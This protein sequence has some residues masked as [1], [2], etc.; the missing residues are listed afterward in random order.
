GLEPDARA[1]GVR[2]DGPGAAEQRLEVTLGEVVRCRL[3]S[4]H[5]AYVPLAGGLGARALPQAA[6]PAGATPRPQRHTRFLLQRP[7]PEPPERAHRV[8]RA[9]AEKQRN[10]EAAVDAEVEAEA[11]LGSN[12]DRELG[13]CRHM[14]A[15]PDRDL[16]AVDGE[17]RLGATD[18]DRRVR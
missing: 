15:L 18:R 6:P 12:A 9:G 16:V 11:G 10:I 4:S 1:V 14:V 2:V 17:R 8:R 3:W 5:H 13:A 7:P